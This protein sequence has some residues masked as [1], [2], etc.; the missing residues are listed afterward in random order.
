[1]SVINYVIDYKNCKPRKRL[2]DKLAE[3]SSENIGGNKMI[4]NGTLDTVPLNDY[5]KICNS[6]RVYM[7]LLT[8]FFMISI[9]ISSLFIYFHWYLKRRYTETTMY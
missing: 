4:Y 5:K 2:I 6:C 8:I 7:V 3:E 9:S 1:M